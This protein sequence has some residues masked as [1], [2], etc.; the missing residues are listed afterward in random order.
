VIQGTSWYLDWYT[1]TI[2]LCS[3]S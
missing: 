2:R 3:Q 1:S